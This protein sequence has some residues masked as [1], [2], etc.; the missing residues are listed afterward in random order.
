M[1][2]LLDTAELRRRI[3][4]ADDNLAQ[5]FWAG[6]SAEALVRD[7]AQFI[8]AFLAKA[9]ME[10]LVDTMPV[11]VVLDPDVALVGAALAADELAHQSN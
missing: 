10:A 8:D 3:D 7:R 4:I 6:T 1:S 5:R 2:Q 11:A 9:P